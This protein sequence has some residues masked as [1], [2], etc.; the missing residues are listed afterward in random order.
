MATTAAA[1]NSN[2]HQQIAIT[3]NLILL[4]FIKIYLQHIAVIVF[5]SIL[6]LIES[7]ILYLTFEIIEQKIGKFV[8]SV[9]S[10]A[11]KKGNIH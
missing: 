6:N 9:A 7:L 10:I 4:F 8:V 3:F 11:V 2:K 5:H 1:S